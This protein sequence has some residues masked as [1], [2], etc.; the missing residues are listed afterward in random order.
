MK[1]LTDDYLSDCRAS[2]HEEQKLSMAIT[3]GWSHVDKEKVHADWDSLYRQ[4][5]PLVGTCA[6]RSDEVQRLIAQHYGIA[7]RF[8]VPSREA[9]IGLGMFYRENPAMRQFHN[10]YHPLMAEFL[11]M[12]LREYALNNL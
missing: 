2:L 8:Y 7:S 11:E 12:A 9:Y 5:A 10:S 6:P 4:L 3:N 1:T